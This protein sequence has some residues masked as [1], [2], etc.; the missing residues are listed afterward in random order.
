MMRRI[1]ALVISGCLVVGGGGVGVAGLSYGTHSPRLL[2]AGLLAAV[3][4][5][6]LGG[7]LLDHAITRVADL[8]ARPDSARARRAA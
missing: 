8:K 2:A 7:L 1:F 5:A 4:G 3:V 6:L